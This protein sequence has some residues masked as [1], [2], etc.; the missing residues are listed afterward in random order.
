MGPEPPSPPLPGR[1]IAGVLLV[2]LRTPPN[3]C[4]PY[5]IGCPSTSL[6]R[7]SY[8]IYVDPGGPNSSLVR[9]WIHVN[10]MGLVSKNRSLTLFLY[11]LRRVP[12]RPCAA[13]GVPQ[14]RVP[15][16]RGNVCRKSMATAAG[17]KDTKRLYK[18]TPDQP[19]VAAN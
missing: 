19:P 6:S 16:E 5:G 11:Y 8:I 18:I 14:G 15:Q 9:A 10:H 2:C 7:H 4:K 12:Q 13:R 3:P 17:R 1:G